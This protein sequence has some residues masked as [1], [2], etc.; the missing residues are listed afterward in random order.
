MRVLLKN[1]C[2]S[3][4]ST[5]TAD[6]SG[7]CSALFELGGMC[8][9]HDASGCNSTY[10]THDEPRWYDSDSLVFISGLSEM[11]AVMGD[12]FKL[13]RDIT[14]AASELLPRFVAIAGT[15]IPAMIGTDFDAVAAEVSKNTGI[16]AFGTASNGMK[17]YICGASS[18]FECIVKHFA[19]KTERTKRMSLNVLGTTPLDFS[20]NGYVEDMYAYLEESGFKI[21]AKLGMGG[22]LE[23]VEKMGNAWV[24]LVVSSAGLA[25]ARYLKERFGTPYVIGAPV[26]GEFSKTLVDCLKT[27]AGDTKSRTAYGRREGGDTVIIGEAVTANSIA[28]YAYQK[29]GV[30]LTVICPPETDS[31][32]GF[33]RMFA[34]EN[35]LRKA[36]ATA[37]HIIADPLFK[38]VCPSGAKFT[39]FP[40]E[41]FSG[42]IYRENIPNLMK[43]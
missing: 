39:E 43:I 36:L 27:V 4:I 8:V 10:N 16:P 19:G 14:E 23:D 11:D 32:C 22:R 24:N 37:R 15:P 40:H 13:I 12:D 6:V 2:A 29:Y 20:V 41:A 21:C 17:S 9:M 5:Y 38:P 26:G 28:E 33:D 25:A 1:Q 3:I 31:E 42:R 35:D 18:A 7:V 34:G 30:K